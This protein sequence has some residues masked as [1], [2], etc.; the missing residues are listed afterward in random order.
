M[1]ARKQF[2]P[3][4]QR[5]NQKYGAPFGRSFPM[6]RLLLKALPGSIYQRLRGPFAIQT[7]NSTRAF[8]YPWA[9]YA[10]DIRAGMN[11]LE[12]GGGLSGF[13]FVLSRLGCSVVNVDPGLH[14]AGVGFKC[15]LESIGLLN[16]RFGTSVQLKST[17]IDKAE[18]QPES[19][20]RAFSISVIEHLASGE[21]RTIVEHV[22]N[23]LKPDGFFVVTLDLSLNIS[24]FTTRRT[25]EFGNNANVREL[26]EAAPWDLVLACEMSCTDSLSSL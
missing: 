10:T 23:L 3:D 14:A 9:F 12:V 4:F 13:Q 17:T 11:V 2:P 21:M 20:D 25:N 15:D 19:F 16:K 5:W 24:P 7:N 26:V 8:E 1:I 18:L 6:A 22:W